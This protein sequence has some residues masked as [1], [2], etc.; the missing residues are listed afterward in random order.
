MGVILV[1]ARFHDEQ[2]SFKMEKVNLIIKYFPNL[3]VLFE[4][5]APC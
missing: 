3:L 2:K 5:G 1:P 4:F